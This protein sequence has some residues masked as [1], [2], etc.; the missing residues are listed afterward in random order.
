MGLNRHIDI[1]SVR[2]ASHLP[3]TW[4][5]VF[6]PRPK[7]QQLLP[8][9]T[10]WPRGVGT[11]ST[12]GNPFCLDPPKQLGIPNGEKMKKEE[13]MKKALA[14]GPCRADRRCPQSQQDHK[15]ARGR[16]SL[17]SQKH[18]KRSYASS[19]RELWKRKSRPK[20]CSPRGQTFTKAGGKQGFSSRLSAAHTL[21]SS[22]LLTK[23]HT[24]LH[25]LAP[26]QLIVL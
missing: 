2:P 8:R 25:P 6:C 7:Q 16:R 21:N 23:I 20:L 13:K 5:L 14:V 26:L 1:T 19:C 11:K 4:P 22:K 15:K 17:N 9:E 3:K 12:D 24:A 18:P 10:R